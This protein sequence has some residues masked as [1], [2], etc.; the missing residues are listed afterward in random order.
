MSAGIFQDWSANR[1]SP[2]GRIVMLFFRVCQRVRRWPFGL[3]VLGT[4]LL[5]TYVFFVH[6]VL[7]IELDYQTDIGRGL[8]IRHGV[9]IVVHRDAV[10]GEGCTLRQAVTIGERVPGGP[11]PV[12]GNRVET[13]AG[14]IILGG[15]RLGDGACVGAG[16]VVLRD[17]E[18]G[19]V[20]AGNPAAVI[21]HDNR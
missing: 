14:A 15:I 6:W 20:V 17:V 12:L 11:C 16:S 18:A 1:G 3:W 13:G 19:A 2:K 4:P 21:R 9:G 8:S 7:G 5:A 10:I